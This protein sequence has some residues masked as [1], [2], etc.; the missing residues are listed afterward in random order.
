TS[1]QSSGS[2]R[3]CPRRS[4]RSSF[5]LL[6]SILATRL[7]RVHTRS[8]LGCSPA[9]VNTRFSSNAHHHGSL[10]QRLGA[11]LRPAPESRSRG[12]FPHLSRTLTYSP[13]RV[14]HNALLLRALL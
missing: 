12:T 3:T 7:R 14:V 9:R 6:L 13:G 11:G 5:R 1:P 4:R 8:S 2:T 10:P